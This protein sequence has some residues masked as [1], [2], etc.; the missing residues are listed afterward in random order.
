[1][2]IERLFIGSIAVLFCASAHA[3]VWDAAGDW[4]PPFNP[5][6]VWSYGQY[7]SMGNF[8]S[9]VYDSFNTQYDWNYMPGS[10][11]QIWENN[12]GYARYGVNPGQVSLDSAYGTAVVRFTAPTTGNY[13][14]DIAIGGT[15]IPEH[16]AEGNALAQYGNVS[17][18]GT[19]VG[20]TSFISNIALWTFSSPLTAGENVDA[21]VSDIGVPAAANTALTFTVNAVPEPASY[22]VLGVGALGLL[23]RRKRR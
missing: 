22:L 21:Y 19:I 11:A 4:N 18:G 17:V 14:F 8:E 3:Q 5:N 15:E 16:G 1:M 2:K 6:G 7:N 10:G 12:Y 13:S 23:I 20:R 9:L